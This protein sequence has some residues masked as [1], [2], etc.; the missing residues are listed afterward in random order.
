M[1][2][3][4]ITPEL[5]ATIAD[6]VGG[7]AGESAR[8]LASASTSQPTAPQPQ[9][10][11]QPAP[12][13]PPQQPQGQPKVQGPSPSP[14]EGWHKYLKKEGES[15]SPPPAPSK[16]TKPTTPA[17]PTP[18]TQPTKPTEASWQAQPP[19]KRRAPSSAQPLQ[20]EASWQTQPPPKRK[21][22]PQEQAPPGTDQR[23]QTPLLDE[24]IDLGDDDSELVSLDEGGQIEEAQRDPFIASILELTN[25]GTDTYPEDA[26]EEERQQ[27]RETTAQALQLLPTKALQAIQKNLKGISYRRY[28]EQMDNAYLLTTKR[29]L[30]RQMAK[31]NY[32][33]EKIAPYKERVE[34]LEKKIARTGKAGISGFYDP[35]TGVM[36]L[37]GGPDLAYTGNP[38]YGYPKDDERATAVHISLHE[39]SHVIDHKHVYSGTKGWKTAWAKEIN[40]KPIRVGPLTLRK[41]TLTSY[42]TKSPTE[43]FAEFGRALYS[44]MVP[45]EVLEK[46]FPECSAFFKAQ[47]LWPT[48]RHLP[49]RGKALPAGGQQDRL[50]PEIFD[51]EKWEEFKELN[52]VISTDWVLGAQQAPM[53]SPYARKYLSKKQ[54][55]KPTHVNPPT[56]PKGPTA[57]KVK[58][59]EG[60]DVQALSIA[61]SA[62]KPISQ[63]Y[64]SPEQPIQAPQTPP[65]QDQRA[66]LEEVKREAQK[67][68]G[69]DHG[70]KLAHWLRIHNLNRS[71]VSQFEAAGVNSLDDLAQILNNNQRPQN[72]VNL[73]LFHDDASPFAILSEPRQDFQS[74]GI[75][76]VVVGAPYASR[77]HLLEEAFPSVHFMA[78]EEAPKELED[79]AGTLEKPLPMKSLLP[80]PYARKDKEGGDAKTPKPP[81]TER[82]PQT[83]SEPEAPRESRKPSPPPSEPDPESASSTPSGSDTTERPERVLTEDELRDLEGDAYIQPS[84]RRSPKPPRGSEDALIESLKGVH[85]ASRSVLA[86]SFRYHVPMSAATRGAIKYA[87]QLSQ[88]ALRLGTP[89]AHETAAKIQTVLA[90]RHSLEA[91]SLSVNVEAA[92]KEG[93]YTRDMTRALKLNKEAAVAAIRA[94][95]AHRLEAHMLR[96]ASAASG[97]MLGKTQEGPESTPQHSSKPK[98]APEEPKQP[99]Q[100]ET[101]QQDKPWVPF[102]KDDTGER[103]QPQPTTGQPEPF[104][105]WRLQRSPG[106]QAEERETPQEPLSNLTPE[107]ELETFIQQQEN[108]YQEN[109]VTFLEKYKA[110][111][112]STEANYSTPIP[113]EKEIEKAPLQP[114]P[115][116]RTRGLHVADMGVIEAGGGRFCYKG[117][118]SDWAVVHE[119]STSAIAQRLGV[120]APL[121]RKTAFRNDP[122]KLLR[123]ESGNAHVPPRF[124]TYANLGRTHAIVSSWIE[125]PTVGRL[126]RELTTKAKLQSRHLYP[127]LQKIL[128]PGE[129]DRQILFAYQFCLE[130]RHAGQYIISGDQLVSFDHEMRDPRKALPEANELFAIKY[131]GLFGSGADHERTPLD[132]EIA[133]E[134]A[135]RTAKAKVIDFMQASG[136]DYPDYIMEV[137][138]RSMVLQA[139]AQADADDYRTFTDIDHETFLDYRTFAGGLEAS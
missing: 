56:T 112:P 13:P 88:I 26:G 86:N 82:K 96:R 71:V 131:E 15:P 78:V 99:E 87:E 83:P 111:Y 38:R 25:Q 50:I 136:L 67:Y 22:V 3:N 101:P 97:K 29:I 92:R 55:R 5:L 16:P 47:G 35:T 79:A 115:D 59:P 69:S 132:R 108:R 53:P 129:I 113:D 11:Q 45:L 80:S 104:E 95:A 93:K 121:V 41:Y 12:A 52:D 4:Q 23:T 68:S 133:K 123:V 43:G 91:D 135:T 27:Y 125:G 39:K 65:P 7:L 103:Q 44:G 33:K 28:G 107:Q 37:D 14:Y 32:P 75:P 66:I 126:M 58:P 76:A 64:A 98:P 19:P 10:E 134:L 122:Q 127:F 51:S 49:K 63:P 17:K 62:K 18:Q 106:D 138:R 114:I 118:L 40:R 124:D 24:E 46:D 1:S 6:I 70:T 61:A 128:R 36:Y 54:G 102:P 77:V 73:D 120:P 34:R 105:L 109:L 84:K 2:I 89:N 90:R 100:P 60:P 74:G 117:S 30:Q 48:S 116:P 139:F 31:P 119:E 57:L 20:T 130:D 85:D 42:S 21:P 9:P 8:A 81:Q 110:T 72:A 94:A 137:A